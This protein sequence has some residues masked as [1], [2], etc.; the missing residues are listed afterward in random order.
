VQADEPLKNMP[1]STVALREAKDMRE[2]DKDANEMSM[3]LFRRASG[4]YSKEPAPGVI[5][6]AKGDHK[7]IQCSGVPDAPLFIHLTLK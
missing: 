7:M 4:S 3:T 6:S 2:S 1:I 5:C